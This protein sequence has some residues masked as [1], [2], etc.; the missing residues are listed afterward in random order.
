MADAAASRGALKWQMRAVA[1]ELA[2]VAPVQLL[3]A[4]QAASRA[5]ALVP[6]L[7]LLVLARAGPA[8][9]EPVAVAAE[10]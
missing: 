2:A 7:L 3:Q 8:A 5:A 6:S 4:R 1:Q 9:V 10:R